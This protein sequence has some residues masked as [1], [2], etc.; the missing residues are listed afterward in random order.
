MGTGVSPWRPAVAL[1]IVASVD[2]ALTF[3]GGGG[4]GIIGRFVGGFPGRR[5]HS[6]TFSAQHKHLLWDGGAFRG[7]LGGV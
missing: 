2:L 3:G 1:I 6:S 5:L 4:G 7:C